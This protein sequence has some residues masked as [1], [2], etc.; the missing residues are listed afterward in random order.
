MY[1]LLEGNIF[2]TALSFTFNKYISIRTS[3]P[4]TFSIWN[5]DGSSLFSLLPT[6]RCTLPICLLIL[7][8]L[9]K[10]I[11][12]MLYAHL[13]LHLLY[14]QVAKI[15]L[16]RKMLVL[17]F[18]SLP[19]AI[20]DIQGEMNLSIFKNKIKSFHLTNQQKL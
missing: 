15:I 1:S 16:S 19:D 14:C 7:P 20:C 6:N 4:L 18:N 2:K 17:F 13:P 9:F 12:N 3:L 11:Q 5:P 8:S 10:T